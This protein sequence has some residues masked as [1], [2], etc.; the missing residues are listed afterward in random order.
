MNA[1]IP[2]DIPLP[3]PAA[4]WFLKTLLVLSFLVHILFVNLM[5]GGAILCL[6]YEIRGRT[7][8]LYDQLAYFI[9]QTITVNKSLAVVLGVA[10]LLLINV[11]YTV[12]FYSANALT[13]SVW[14]LVVP[15]VAAA[16]LLTYLHKYTW[17]RMEKFKTIHISIIAT[18]VGL[19]LFIPLIF[20][21]NINLMLFPEKWGAVNG[22]FSALTLPNVFPRY[23]HFLAASMAVTSLFL[24]WVVKGNRWISV[25]SLIVENRDFLIRQFY[26]IALVVSS[27]QFLIGPLILVTLPS[28]GLSVKMLVTIFTGVT[29]AIP[30]IWLMW[31]ELQ[32]K[33]AGERVVKI[34]GLLGFTVIFMASGRHFYRDQ[35]LANHKKAVELKTVE[36]QKLVK[37]AQASSATLSLVPGGDDIMVKGKQLAQ[38]CTACHGVDTRVVGPPIKEIARLYAGNPDGIVAWAKAPGRKRADYPAMPAMGLPD[39]DLKI[40]AEYMLKI[41]K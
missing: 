31:K 10:P 29:F 12:W 7:N 15:S 11:L 4:E 1:P 35:A 17:E 8:R 19:F 9:A 38:S 22:F 36:Y 34:A 28:H 21:T 25:D 23:F 32:S 3:L 16:F 5:V 40:I 14:I 13:G 30:A 33:Q 20:L 18:A 37:E 27:L 26:T 6:V 2:H 39:A 41:G 24:V